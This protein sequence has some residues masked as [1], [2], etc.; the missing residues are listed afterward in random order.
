[1]FDAYFRPISMTRPFHV[2]AP[3]GTLLRQGQIGLP[4]GGCATLVDEDEIAYALSTEYAELPKGQEVIVEGRLRA[5][6]GCG[7][8][9]RIEVTR[10]YPRRGT[11]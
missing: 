6:D 5:T 10:L 9:P 2:T 7:G 11:S 3:D 8:L 4:V 1:V